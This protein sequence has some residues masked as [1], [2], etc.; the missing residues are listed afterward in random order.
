MPSES[1]ASS[2]GGNSQ[3]RFLCIDKRGE[4]LPDEVVAKLQEG[5]KQILG[6]P[7]DVAEA[8][9]FCVS[10]P[11]TANIADIVV[12]PPQQLNL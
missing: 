12:R 10:M 5:M 6:S 9:L 3:S 11:I 8:V 7:D 4:R 2:R 1:T